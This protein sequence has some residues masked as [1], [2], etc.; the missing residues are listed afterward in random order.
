MPYKTLFLASI[1]VDK[2][3]RL[4]SKP[5]LR[6]LVLESQLSKYILFRLEV[7]VKNLESLE[8]RK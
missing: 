7:Q 5:K 4:V 3:Y 6:F 2:R 1:N 8:L